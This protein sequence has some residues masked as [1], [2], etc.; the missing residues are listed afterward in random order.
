MLHS[1]ARRKLQNLYRFCFE[2]CKPN[3][4]ATGQDRLQLENTVCTTGCAQHHPRT[5]RLSLSARSRCC[6]TPPPS[7]SVLTDAG[8]VYRDDDQ[9]FSL[10]KHIWQIWQEDSKF[11]IWTFARHDDNSWKLIFSAAFRQS[12]D[13]RS[14][15]S[16]H[17][18]LFSSSFV[19]TGS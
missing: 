7:L 19:P 10:G 3:Q 15:S 2:K 14:C 6:N 1:A 12:V 13:I 18:H 4:K 11:I 9:L 16:H 17:H 8:R 5:V